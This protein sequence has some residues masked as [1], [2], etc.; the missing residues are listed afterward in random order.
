MRALAVR[1]TRSPVGHSAEPEEVTGLGGAKAECG[2]MA[3]K[4]SRKGYIFLIGEM[5]RAHPSTVRR[6]FAEDHTIG[7]HSEDHPVRFGKLPAPH[8][9]LIKSGVRLVADSRHKSG[10]RGTNSPRQ[11]NVLIQSK[12]AFPI[13]SGESS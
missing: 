12:M 8:R 4:A 6:I 10:Q 13:S 2:S 5:A 7:T 1:R 11:P 9:V 3:G